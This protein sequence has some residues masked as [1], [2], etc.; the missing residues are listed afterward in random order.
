MDEQ[1]KTFP[2][3]RRWL[4]LLPSEYF[5]RQCYISFE[6]G[7]ATL[8]S[9]TAY[10]GADRIIWASDYPHPEYEPHVVD[11]LLANTTSLDAPARR[12]VVGDNAR[13]AYRL[14]PIGRHAPPRPAPAA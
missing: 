9:S 6:P 7:E 1:V 3:E 14:P 10:L 5:R 12:Q 8:A 11:E 2:L 13:A 4:S